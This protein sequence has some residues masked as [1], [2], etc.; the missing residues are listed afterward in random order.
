MDS[1]KNIVSGVIERMSSGNGVSF[2]DIQAAWAKISKDQAS[3]VATEAAVSAG[4]LAA[5][6]PYC[7]NPAASARS[8]ASRAAATSARAF[9]S[10]SRCS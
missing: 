4:A 3:R 9:A 8:T 10:H 1:I 5:I 6:P 2:K 7:P